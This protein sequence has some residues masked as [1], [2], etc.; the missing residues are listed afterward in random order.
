VSLGKRFAWADASIKA[1]QI[2]EKLLAHCER[3]CVAGSIRR[4]QPWVSDI[5][6]VVI[7]KWESKDSLFGMT[8][9]LGNTDFYAAV[10]QE[11][12][13]ITAEGTKLIRG[14][15][16]IATSSSIGVDLY[17]AT[18]ESW[19]TLL[20]VRT[21]SKEHNIWMCSRAFHCGGKLHADGSGLELAG[22]YDP[23]RQRTMVN[24]SQGFASTNPETRRLVQPES[25]EEIFKL[26]G[27]PYAE[28]KLRECVNARPVWMGRGSSESLKVG[29]SAGRENSNACDVRDAAAGER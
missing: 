23:I 19:A 17:V 7:P 5:D 9:D 2:G 25:E 14:K 3:I 22:Q 24:L 6:L 10:R 20:L 13:D 28:P 21:G 15:S 27:L 12:W 4:M 1:Q 11:L 8:E 18:P 26:L 29:R 16:Y